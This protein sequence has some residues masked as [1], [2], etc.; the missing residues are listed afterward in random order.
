[1][2]RPEHANIDDIPKDTQDVEPDPQLVETDP[3]EEDPDPHV[4]PSA[5]ARLG[6]KPLDNPRAGFDEYGAELGLDARIWPVYVKE[7][8]AWDG[9]MV[10]GWNR[11]LDVMLIFVRL[12]LTALFSAVSTTFVVESFKML[13]PDPSQTSANALIEITQLL[14]TM[15]NGGNTASIDTS[16][17]PA[18]FSP[19]ASAI[20]INALWFLSLAL[21]VSVSLIVMLAKQWCY[22]YMSGRL[23]QP[24]IQARTRQRR[25]EELERWR[26]P[27]IL[28][29]LPSLIHL[30]LFLFF[31]G[32]IISLWD[33]HVGVAA[34]VLATT[35]ITVLFYSLTTV[36]P[37]K[38]E[39]CPYNTPLSQLLKSSPANMRWLRHTITGQC[40][41]AAKQF[42]NPQGLWANIRFFFWL[43]FSPNSRRLR[44][45]KR[46]REAVSGDPTSEIVMDHLSSRALSWL[47]A[48]SQDT[49][50]VD[51]ALQ[52]IAGAD[53]RLPT[54]PLLECGAH[55]LLAQRFRGCFISHPQ[56]GFSF[57]T[58]SSSA[59]VASL[60]GRALE[61]FMKDKK[62]VEV[63]DGV[64]KQ[65]P[66]GGFAIRRAYQ[67]LQ[68]DLRRVRPNLAAFGLSGVSTWWAMRGHNGQLPPGVLEEA[69][70]MLDRHIT[71]E[72]T[73]HPV[74]LVAVIDK[75]SFE[76]QYW[77]HQLTPR[78]RALYPPAL[79]R[80]LNQLDQA[81]LGHARPAIA[82]CLASFS[83]L[84]INQPFDLASKMSHSMRSP[85][86]LL[87]L[88]N[89][90]LDEAR[91]RDA[92]PLL[93]YGL[94]CLLRDREA[95]EFNDAE[96]FMIAQQL[97]LANYLRPPPSGISFP[98]TP[99]S[100]D[101]G[102]MT[103]KS[104][105]H[106]LSPD[107]RQTLTPDAT[108]ELLRAL[109]PYSYMWGNF[110]NAVYTTVASLI[111]QPRSQPVK[112]AWNDWLDSGWTPY[113]ASDMLHLINHHRT[114]EHI[115]GLLAEN[116]LEM[117][118]V[119]FAIRYTLSTME[120]ILK[121]ERGRPSHAGN[122]TH[123]ALLQSIALQFDLEGAGARLTTSKLLILE[124]LRDAIPGDILDSGVLDVL[125][126]MNV[127]RLSDRANQLSE[128][129]VAHVS[130]L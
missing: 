61:Y 79:L 56:S 116:E 36:L 57:L 86:G 34:P 32:L 75:I 80:L 64:L 96:I 87:F 89:Y 93:F 92:E 126:R 111:T 120:Q 41:T 110:S 72:S 47:V 44:P 84:F 119:P 104:L 11:S 95:Y 62:H 18:A 77:M 74:A 99:P 14:R 124:G 91:S 55:N 3:Q 40:V 54:K 9:E 102:I 48:N 60:Y 101:L 81:S 37:I 108:G 15:S 97:G 42:A 117:S 71:S 63:V 83:F 65:G 51:L 25:L 26:M 38:Y 125:V 53:Y 90:E 35:A 113:Y 8:E 2:H 49:R 115:V 82:A 29:F 6:S 58:N 12:Y 39:L 68:Y 4:H 22:S 17:D 103:I 31:V 1:M 128:Y 98:F 130:S 59:D 7:A 19:P 45:R 100:F 70:G 94:L 114:F 27:E 43:I 24:H 85:L 28:A 23:G 5:E 78:E 52:A 112:F 88:H 127:H 109:M 16:T 106:M 33:A 69:L 10:D 50:S 66:G 123:R 67:C 46:D 13:Q 30:S 76:A 21:S 121:F 105:L 20:W 118:A 73:L 129:C 122:M 107:V